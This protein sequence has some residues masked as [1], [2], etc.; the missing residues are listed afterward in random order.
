MPEEIE[1]KR[2][3]REECGNS[4]PPPFP[5][6]TMAGGTKSR[7]RLAPGRYPGYKLSITEALHVV[8]VKLSQADDLRYIH[9]TV[10]VDPSQNEFFP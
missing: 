1:G 6:T 8:S 4:S 3:V 7:S 5:S 9:R 10:L 2:W